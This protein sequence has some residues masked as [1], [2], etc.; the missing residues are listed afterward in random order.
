LR[1]INTISFDE[2]IQE[3]VNEPRLAKTAHHFRR[4]SNR[5]AGLLA[6]LK[7]LISA[8]KSS[9]SAKT[10]RNGKASSANNLPMVPTNWRRLSSPSSKKN[11]SN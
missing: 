5:A 9:R 7:W 6:V 3:S 1:R 8:S 4:L 10:N 11:S 2:I